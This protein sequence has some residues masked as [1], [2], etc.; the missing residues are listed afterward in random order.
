MKK[1]RKARKMA[2]IDPTKSVDSR[3]SR[4]LLNLRTYDPRL[5]STISEGL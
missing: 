4:A 1:Q 2:D 3:R 5:G